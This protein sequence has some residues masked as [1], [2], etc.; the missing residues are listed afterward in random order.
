MEAM[1]TR[2]A[3]GQALV[4]IGEQNRDLVVLD[5]DLAMATKTV[6][7]KTRFPE[8]FFDM[9]IAEQSM[10]GTAAGLALAGKIPFASSF[11]VFATGRA[12]EQIRNSVAYPKVNVKIAATHAGITVGEDGASHQSVADISLMRSLPNMT[13]LVPA[14]GVETAQAVRA[15]AEFQGPVYLRLGRLKVPVVV[16][17][18]HRFRIGPA[19]VLRQGADAVVFACGIMVGKALEAALELAKEGI[20][21]TVVNVPTI[22]P[23]DS[24]TVVKVARLT[25]AVVTA[26]EHSVIG[27][28][29]SAVA[30]V[31][32][33]QYPVPLEM[34]GLRDCF[35]E[36]GP[37]DQLL[38]KFGLTGAEIMRAVK[39]VMIRK[40]S[41]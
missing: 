11:A 34:V 4:E 31:L 17:E 2:D 21:V 25:G 32:G 37:P 10:I 14:D 30:E 22:K 15:A 35:G 19:Y 9:G 12:F 36:S 29:G 16:G 26:E 6:A 24:E 39:K 3:Y 1:A 13:V 40:R 38:V 33:Q 27:G 7:F 5:A 8:R 28:L 18:D 41:R 23:L 20:E